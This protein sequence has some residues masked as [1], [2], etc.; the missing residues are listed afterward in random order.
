MLVLDASNSMAKDGKFDA[1]TAAVDAYLD[2]APED[3]AIGLVTFAGNVVETD[4]ADHRPRRRW[5][6]RSTR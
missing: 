5:P 3:V 4:R 1:A 2:A 6:L